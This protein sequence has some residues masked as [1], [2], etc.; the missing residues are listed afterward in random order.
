LQVCP[1]QATSWPTV[2]ATP[3]AQAL[4]PAGGVLL[5]HGSRSS[6]G[7][8][9]PGPPTAKPYRS[10][11]SALPSRSCSMSCRPRRSAVLASSSW[12][13]R[14][15]SARLRVSGW[16]G[17]MASQAVR[18]GYG[19]SFMARFGVAACPGGRPA[20]LPGDPGFRHPVAWADCARLA[21]L[22]GPAGRAGVV[23]VPESSH[24]NCHANYHAS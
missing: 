6:C 23:L 5:P 9:G 14:L 13:R 21:G 17:A 1:S 8:P 24:A 11:R 16:L 20:G 2:Q 19:M 3:T 10:T 15:R 18:P 7:G 22:C 4:A 12:G